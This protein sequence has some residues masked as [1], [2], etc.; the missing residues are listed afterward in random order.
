MGAYAAAKSAVLRLTESLADE[1][2]ASGV[3]VNCVLPSTID[4]PQ[5]RAAMPKADF[6]RWVTPSQVAAVIAFLLSDDGSGVT[7]AAVPS[8]GRG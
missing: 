2:K 7:G 5:N 8:I 6:G 1:L 3:R 4:T